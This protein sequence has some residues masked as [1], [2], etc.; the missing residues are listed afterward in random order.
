MAQDDKAADHEEER[1]HQ[2][3]DLYVL[4]V[5]VPAGERVLSLAIDKIDEGPAVDRETEE[6]DKLRDWQPGR[7]HL[8]AVVDI[9]KDCGA[10]VDVRE[11]GGQM[12]E[13]GTALHEKRGATDAPEDVA[14]VNRDVASEL[15][16]FWLVRSWHDFEQNVLVLWGRIFHFLL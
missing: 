8:E 13:E 15:L 3:Q 9:F 11:V 12:L 6:G 7:V 5:V 14:P 1:S 4:V 2:E 16:P 10:G